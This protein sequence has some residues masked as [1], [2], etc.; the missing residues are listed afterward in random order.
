MRIDGA[1]SA[2][3]QPTEQKG[4]LDFVNDHITH[5]L[6][7]SHFTTTLSACLFNTTLSPQLHCRQAQRVPYL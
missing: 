5:H 1:V 7:I 6:V 3:F 4:A 2:S